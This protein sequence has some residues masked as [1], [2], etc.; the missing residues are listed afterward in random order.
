MRI[1]DADWTFDGM[2]ALWQ[3]DEVSADP[4]IASVCADSQY[5]WLINN[6]SRMGGGWQFAGGAFEGPAYDGALANAEQL[7]SESIDAVS[8]WIENGEI[9][10]LNDG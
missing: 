10:E 3:E 8:G 7:V 2:A 1:S 6:A 5:A 4:E 9:F